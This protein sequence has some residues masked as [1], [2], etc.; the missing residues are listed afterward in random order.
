MDENEPQG[1]TES[2]NV[3]FHLRKLEKKSKVITK[4]HMEFPG[5]PVVK[6]HVSTG[7]VMGSIPSGG[8]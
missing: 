5:R 3:S 6:T 8:S 4:K 2:R 7:G 1:K